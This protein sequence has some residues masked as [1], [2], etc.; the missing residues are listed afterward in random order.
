ML[1]RLPAAPHPTLPACRHPAAAARPEP[2]DVD[3][4]GHRRLHVS[5]ASVCSCLCTG[6]PLPFR[7]SAH[8]ASPLLLLCHPVVAPRATIAAAN[9][10][11]DWP[12]VYAASAEA[13]AAR[14]ELERLVAAGRAAHAPLAMGTRYAQPFRVQVRGAAGWGVQRGL[15]ARPDREAGGMAGVMTLQRTPG[16]RCCSNPSL[17]AACSCGSWWPSTGRVRLP[18]PP[19]LPARPLCVCSAARCSSRGRRAPAL[20]AAATL[21]HSPLLCLLPPAPPPPPPPPPPHSTTP[22]PPVYYRMPA[23]NL[24]RVVMCFL[25]SWV[26]A[27]TY[28]KAGGRRRGGGGGVDREGGRRH[29]RAGPGRPRSCVWHAASRARGAC[30][31]LLP[32]SIS[33]PSPM[34]HPASPLRWA[35]CPTPP[36][37]RPS[38]TSWASCSRR[39]TFWVSL[40]RARGRG[41]GGAGGSRKGAG[42]SRFAPILNRPG[43][44][45]AWANPCLPACSR[46]LASIAANPPTTAH[47]PPNPNPNPT[48]P[49]GM[50]NMMSVM[51]VCGAERLVYYRGGRP[52]GWRRLGTP[53]GKGAA[54]G[55]EAGVLRPG[56]R[57][58]SLPKTPTCDAPCPSFPP[59]ESGSATYN[60]FPY[61]FAL[62]M[63][64]VPWIMLQVRAEGE[65]SC[66]AD[67]AA[68][69]ARRCQLLGPTALCTPEASF[70]AHP[71]NPRHTPQSVIFAPIVYWMV[72][73][74]VRMGQ[75]KGRGRAQLARAP[76]PAP[77]PPRARTSRPQATAEKFF[78]YFVL[79]TVTM[80]FYT[81]FG[82]LLV[83]GREGER[84]PTSNAGCAAGAGCSAAAL[85]LAGV[86]PSRLPA[87]QTAPGVDDAVAAAGPDPGQ[88]AVLHL[89]HQQREGGEG[90][91]WG[92]GGWAGSSEAARRRRCGLRPPMAWTRASGAC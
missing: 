73:F 57:T 33:A 72:G 78:H 60:V 85:G 46:S 55:D 48:S 20:V 76:H 43:P 4:G 21:T 1:L 41:T 27:T 49:P 5:R 77:P 69:R 29:T 88:H 38:R 12:G 63:V 79:F 89:E 61:G 91:G 11:V 75:R 17:R 37:S 42:P 62:A 80:N 22:P 16:G 84:S 7:Y 24:S 18:A 74:Q 30:S 34:H 66:R 15:S 9:A 10:D 6:P 90:V 36:A 58:V 14:S 54:L 23:Y 67:G 64:E 71:P 70:D 87:R 39:P 56:R 8:A 92:G 31:H 53:K 2:G 68:G 82:Q 28:Y 50:T 47:L 3:A 26:Y 51:P 65:G 25:V 19:S 83:R 32:P 45:P 81:T 35:T 52:R 44:G 86:P 59:A 40:L 13:A